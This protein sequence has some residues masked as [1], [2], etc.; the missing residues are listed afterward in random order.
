MSRFTRTAA[1]VAL[2]LSVLMLLPA[3]ALS[4]D[5]F[6]IEKTLSR[7]GVRLVVV[8]FY[9]T[10]CQPC[11]DA[12]PRWKKLHDKYRDQGLRL[13]VVNTRDIS[14]VCVNPGWTPDDMV[15]DLDGFVAD[16]L[17]ASSLPSAF[18]WSWQGNLLTQQGVE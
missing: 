11:M 9:A 12:I 14:G 3:S 8:E 6:N 2:L 7:A 17:G 1:C 13:I 5:T 15:C 18:L 10:W 16:S 4:V